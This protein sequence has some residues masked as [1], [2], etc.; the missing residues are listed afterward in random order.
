MLL[1]LSLLSSAAAPGTEK[2]KCFLHLSSNSTLQLT[3]SISI[4]LQNSLRYLNDTTIAAFSRTPL[5]WFGASWATVFPTNL[6]LYLKDLK[7]LVF[8][9]SA[10]KLVASCLEKGYKLPVLLEQLELHSNIG[11]IKLK[12]LTSST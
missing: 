2:R 6:V 12:S 3:N 10:L 4:D 5:A 11:M 9:I 7:V 8:I 1:G